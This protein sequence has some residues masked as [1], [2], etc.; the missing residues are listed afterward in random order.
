MITIKPAIKN[1]GLTHKQ[2][3]K[4]LYRN[5]P[6]EQ[7]TR[8]YFKIPENYDCVI[9]GKIVTCLSLAWFKFSKKTKKLSTFV[10]SL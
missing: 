8:R 10:A 7:F 6:V 1:T 5:Q 3:G 9:I 4:H 2:P